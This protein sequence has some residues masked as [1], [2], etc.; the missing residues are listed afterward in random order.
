MNPSVIYGIYWID[1]LD[2]VSGVTLYACSRFDSLITK[3][4]TQDGCVAFL[5]STYFNASVKIGTICFLRET[6]PFK[7]AV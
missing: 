2:S 6:T 5:N 4:A 1:C 3:K 7:T